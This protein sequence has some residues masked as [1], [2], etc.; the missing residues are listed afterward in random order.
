MQTMMMRAQYRQHQHK[1]HH[2]QILA[3]A[4]VAEVCEAICL[5]VVTRRMLHN[6]PWEDNRDLLGHLENTRLT[7]KPASY[8]EKSSV[9][10]F[11]LFSATSSTM[12]ALHNQML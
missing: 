8:I 2:H 4:A 7:S 6:H 3:K 10:R 1:G 9:Y 12:S 11:A 5:E